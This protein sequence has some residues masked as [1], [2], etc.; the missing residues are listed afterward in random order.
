MVFSP[1]TVPTGIFTGRCFNVLH[2]P[3]GVGALLPRRA[4]L[5][6][7]LSEHGGTVLSRLETER[8]EFANQLVHVVV[9]TQHMPE[10][11]KTGAVYSGAWVTDCIN[12]KA[13]LQADKSY[14]IRAPPQQQPRPGRVAAVESPGPKRKRCDT[15]FTGQCAERSN[16]PLQRYTQEE[17]AALLA[18]VRDHPDIKASGRKL[19][20]AAA[21]A[22]VTV[23]S[24]QSMRE[25]YT[26]RVRPA[27]RTPHA[28]LT[29]ARPHTH[30]R[31][32]ASS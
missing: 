32:P 13:L 16:R 29:H 1:E 5:I 9:D 23:H 15:V 24:E 14:M 31:A 3:S 17:D 10:L 2:V 26:K 12:A 20:Q 30:A 19:W 6:K 8:P 18:W 7:S 4:A 27:S 11:P 21:S 28:R 22:G 25:R